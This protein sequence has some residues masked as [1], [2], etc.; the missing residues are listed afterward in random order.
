M[1]ALV[2]VVA[3]ALLILLWLWDRQEKCPSCGSHNVQSLGDVLGRP[4]WQ[5]G[6]CFN[7]WEKR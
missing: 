5:C 1:T 6:R 4:F 2:F 3:V 7:Y